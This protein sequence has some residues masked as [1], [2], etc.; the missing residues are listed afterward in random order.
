MPEG[1]VEVELIQGHDLK[2]VETF[3]K[4]DPYCLL[5]CGPVKHRSRTIHDGGSDP[6][7]NQSFLFEIPDGVPEL[8]VSVYDSERNGRDESMGVTVIPLAPLYMNRQI[9]PTKYKVQLPN[10]HFHGELVLRLKF[11]P[12]V[13]HGQLTLH[14]VKGHNLLDADV[15]DKSDPYAIITCHKQKLKSRVIENGGSNPNWDQTFAFTI[16]SEVTEV[17]IKLFDRDTFTADD[18]LGTAIVPLH[19]VFAE[20]Y[21]PP[22]DYKVLGKQGQPQGEVTVGLKYVPKI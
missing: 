22:M 4:S 8:S 16:D 19:K 12:K 5:S 13:H 18:L 21:V 9:E 6:V 3:G 20:G 10:G 17:L 15:F 1:T 2:D 7:W 14:L 11:F